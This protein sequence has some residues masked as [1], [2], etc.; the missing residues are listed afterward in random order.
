MKMGN[1]R[2]ALVI[3]ILAALTFAHA[4]ASATAETMKSFRL[5][6][7]LIDVSTPG[8]HL[9][10]DRTSPK[11]N[12]MLPDGYASNKRKRY[13]VLYWLHGGS[14]GAD[15]MEESGTLDLFR[16]FPGI[17]VIP[18]GGQFGIYMNWWNDGQRGGPAWATYHLTT[19]RRAIEKRYRIRD[20]RRWHSL[21]GNSMGGQGAL[22]YAAMLPG[23]FGSAAGIS[24][25]LPDMQAPEAELGLSVVAGGVAQGVTYPAIFGPADGAYAEGNSSKAVTGNFGHTRLYLTAGSGTKCP[26]DPEPSGSDSIIETFIHA[27]LT[28]FADAARGDGAEVTE[29]P[30]C[31]AHTWETF[32]RAVRGALDWG[33]FRP[34][35]EKP[36][37]WS[38]ETI[39]TSG[40]MWGLNF[41]F[42]SPPD[43]IAGFERKGRS[44]SATGTGR[45]QI[46]AG[47]KCSLIVNLPF[48]RRLSRN[49]LG[50]LN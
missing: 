19:L 43:S 16:D 33:F 50:Y 28:P 8:G 39:A 35:T 24:T 22:R 13:P 4:P 32:H 25:A 18:D 21:A 48:N 26:E 46:K 11:V 5:P 47:K 1:R 12:V 36:K 44:L 14:G 15:T 20:G 23:Y 27:Q 3:A 40:E 38:Y 6:S 37:N 30:G 49:C 29:V 41:R 2:L 45:V 7:P 10:D 34:V 31:G 9:Q 17:V 42:H